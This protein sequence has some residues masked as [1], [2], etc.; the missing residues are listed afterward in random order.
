[1]DDLMRSTGAHVRALTTPSFIHNLPRQVAVIRVRGAFFSPIPPDRRM[2]FVATR[3]IAAVAAELLVDDTWSGQDDRPILGPEDLSFR[4]MASIITEVSRLPVEA[5]QISDEVYREGFMNR[6]Y[7]PEMAQG[8][9]D[10]VT[11]KENGLDAGV[12]RSAKTYWPTSFT[13][14]CTEVL[15]PA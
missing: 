1:M 15:E 6:G 10:M 4:Q 11:A 7:S 2:S 9:L 8:M 14:W 3:D 13:Q 12:A 5:Q